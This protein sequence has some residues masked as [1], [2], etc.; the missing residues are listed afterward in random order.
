MIF[1]DD[2][3]PKGIGNI[4]L[5]KKI[6]SLDLEKMLYSNVL[7]SGKYFSGKTLFLLRMIQLYKE[8]EV[9]IAVFDPCVEEGWVSL[10]STLLGSKIAEIKRDETFFSS[11]EEFFIQ[12][13]TVIE[14]AL[15]CC[16]DV[17]GWFPPIS[18]E[19]FFPGQIFL[20][21]ISKFIERAHGSAND[22]KQMY[23]SLYVQL[24]H[25]ILVK[26]VCLH[27]YVKSPLIIF[28]D[29]VA[30]TPA[31]LNILNCENVYLVSAI[32]T[33]GHGF[34]ETDFFSFH[35]DLDTLYE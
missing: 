7:I 31:L 2:T 1:L 34:G 17:E 33:L 16:Q 26:L 20:F 32:H 9:F 21:D 35:L 14:R 15:M 25:Q 6:C 29:E 11:P 8:R 4:P 30:I 23:T 24:I 12:K 5:W 10:I 19:S 22:L 3:T 27:K 28:T 18:R 13:D